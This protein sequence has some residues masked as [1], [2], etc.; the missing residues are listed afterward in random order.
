M[1][2][3]V[4]GIAE[5]T[6][7][8]LLLTYFFP[9]QVWTL[10]AVLLLL[11]SLKARVRA[12]V[13]GS[14]VALVLAALLLG[15]TIPRS[16]AG[17]SSFRLMTYNL[18]RGAGGTARLADTIRRQQPEVVCL[19]EINGLRAS[20][21]AELRQQLPEYSVVQAREVALLVRL[22][23]LESQE[24]PIP[25]TTRSLLSASLRTKDG[26]V[27]VLDA[28]FTTVPLRAG[29]AQA[30]ES[31]TRQ[32]QLLLSRAQSIPGS[33]VVCGDFNTPPQGRIYT[34]LKR[35]FT[36]AFEQAGS[37]LGLTFPA[38]LP[39][40]RIDHVWLRQAEAIRAYV[41]VSRASDHRPLVVEVHL[42]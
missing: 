31:R 37:G 16:T 13:S 20:M 8:T 12:A 9:P 27:T 41:P 4:T 15:W 26:R 36:N 17:A 28:H 35:H 30:V 42:P 25:G 21:F 14:L 5:R 34:E 22:P 23:L 32:E 7:P 3:A 11:F 2:L 10:C 38:A 40:A 19:Q 6:V 1:N 29:W 24:T 39:V 33:L 18:A